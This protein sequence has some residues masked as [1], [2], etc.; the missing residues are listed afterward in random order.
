MIDAFFPTG[1]GSGTGGLSTLSAADTV[2]ITSADDLPAAVAGVRALDS[3]KAYL[4]HGFFNIGTDQVDLNGASLIGVS[5][6]HCG[7]LTNNAGGLLLANAVSARVK[8]VR[9]I[10]TSG[11]CFA[12]VG[13]AS[14]FQTVIDCL[15]INGAQDTVQGAGGDFVFR[16]G[17]W[18]NGHS[19]VKLTGSFDTV[20]FVL[21]VLRNL[22]DLVEP[23][24]GQPARLVELALGMTVGAFTWLSGGSAPVAGQVALYADPGI[25]PGRG[26]GVLLSDFGTSGGEA[27]G[28]WDQTFPRVT[29]FGNQ[30]LQNST[31]T[32]LM[33]LALNTAQ[34][35]GAG[36]MRIPTNVP[37]VAEVLNERFDVVDV[38]SGPELRMFDLSPHRVGVDA[39]A[40]LQSTA[41]ANKAFQ[42][43]LVKWDDSASTTVVVGQAVP[44]DYQQVAATGVINFFV[45]MEQFDRLY[46]E[47]FTPDATAAICSSASIRALSS[48]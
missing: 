8:E 1:L 21:P 11:P 39:T 35:V 10:N 36:W 7:L 17:T 22:A 13:G 19:G 5:R 14:T 44:V 42:L 41:A 18:A 46:L 47:M 23:S 38:G 28:G 26:A 29:V 27:L 32:G 16:T 43:R 24:P 2:A 20:A 48:S 30:K 15:L 25:L 31:Y 40:V 9:L 37:W 3:T 33:T 12:F 6:D 4:L 34:T 45:D